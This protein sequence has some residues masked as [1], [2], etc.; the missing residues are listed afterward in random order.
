M[1]YHPFGHLGLKVLAVALAALMWTTVSRDSLVERSVRAPL[2]F[3][4]VPDGLEIVN[5]TPGTVDVRVRGTSSLLS[6]LEPGDIVAVLDMR[7]ARPGQ[8]MFHLIADEVR[9]PMGV[10]IVQVSPPTITF[11]FERASSR[12]VPVVPTID[13]DPGPGYIVGEV[14]S[15]PA[16]VEV[17]GPE[18][19][20]REL[21]NATTEPVSIQNAT[22]PVQERV[23]VGVPDGMLRL[24]NGRTAT[25]TVDI[26][27]APIER[28]VVGVRVGVRNLPA[29]R[30]ASLVPDTVAVVVKGP[31]ETLASLGPPDVAV[32]VDLA[33][34]GPG[35][36][37]LPVKGDLAK[38]YRVVRSDPPGVQ[39]RIR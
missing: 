19:R 10:E 3:Q 11:D 26:R 14:S 9:V 2:E 4:N 30:T 22:R 32:F 39:V 12:I 8:R 7:T 5:D 13:G 18:S 38:A 31:R 25:V 20:L 6:R 17:V 16:R 28:T 36:Y 21:H 27:P 37:L 1:A 29:G 24:K 15:D 35:R 23:T 34:L 33:S